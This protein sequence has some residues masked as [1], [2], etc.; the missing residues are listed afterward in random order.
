MNNHQDLPVY[1]SSCPSFFMLFYAFFI[2]P[3]RRSGSPAYPVFDL[4]L[5]E[6]LDIFAYLSSIIF[7]L[8]VLSL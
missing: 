3:N 5:L 4:Y 2:L 6:V 1:L 8:F 7:L